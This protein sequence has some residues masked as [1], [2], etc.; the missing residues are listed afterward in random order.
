MNWIYTKD[1]RVE[2]YGLNFILYLYEYT[3]VDR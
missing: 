3:L 1:I 2:K